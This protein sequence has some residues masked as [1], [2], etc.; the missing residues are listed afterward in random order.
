M[1]SCPSAGQTASM[2]AVSRTGK[3][4]SSVSL[5]GRGNGRSLWPQPSSGFPMNDS[6]L[7]L[8]HDPGRRLDERSIL[9]R[10]LVVRT[11]DGGARG[12]IGSSMS[13]IEILRGPF[14]YILCPPAARPRF[15]P[16]PPR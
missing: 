7:G 2:L 5:I 9:L 1:S 12:H 10:R 3:W 4:R 15:V 14:D 16:P 13:L 6:A 8:G 11:L